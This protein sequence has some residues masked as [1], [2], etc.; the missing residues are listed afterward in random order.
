V[1]IAAQSKIRVLLVDDHPMFRDTM[2]E[3]LA[4]YPDLEVVGEASDGHEAVETVGRLRPTVVLMD[5]NMQK[6]DGI[7]AARLITSQSP[8]V[9]ILGLSCDT[10]QYV[11]YA[12]E[13]AG[14]F[15]VL[16]KGRS[17]DDVYK[18]IQRAV[19]SKMK[20]DE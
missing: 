5:I 14:A 17:G 9:A 2:R 10:R 8:Y 15:E 4:A 3:L 7:T 16:I 20:A 6:M 18:A 19:M 12:M 1:L 13:K 11:V